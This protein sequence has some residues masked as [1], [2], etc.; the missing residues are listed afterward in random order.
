MKLSEIENDMLNYDDVPDQ[1]IKI[2]PNFYIHNAIITA[3]KTLMVSVLKSS[4]SDGIIAYM[5]FIEHI[6]VLARAAK[7]I[8]Q[9]YFT[10]VNDF[11]ESKE[12]TEIE[13]KDIQMAKLANKKLLFLMEEV[14]GRA[15]LTTPLKDS[16]DSRF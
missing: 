8:S 6:E 2:N 14:F 13:R 7:Y 5:V 16:G 10:K 11:K 9:D 4:V 1:D 12:Y 3:Q 15:P